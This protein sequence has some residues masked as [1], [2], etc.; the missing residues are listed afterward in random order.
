MLV[1][2]KVNDLDFDAGTERVELCDTLRDKFE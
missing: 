1:A 2:R